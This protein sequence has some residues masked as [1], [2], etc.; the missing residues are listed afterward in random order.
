MIFTNGQRSVH[1]SAD[2]FTRVR[3]CI[4]KRAGLTVP[5]YSDLTEVATSTINILIAADS[6]LWRMACQGLIAISP[7]GTKPDW[8]FEVTHPKL[9][10]VRCSL[11]T[12]QPKLAHGV[13][14]PYVAREIDELVQ[15]TKFIGRPLSPR[16]RTRVKQDVIRRV[17]DL[18][19]QAEEA[20]VAFDRLASKFGR[21][22]KR[23]GTST[24]QARVTV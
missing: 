13:K 21:E 4:I 20:M 16:R 8:F 10:P 2:S 7:R 9:V 12:R 17:I 14:H 6:L 11:R 23:T 15:I 3:D 18:G 5:E 19:L 1:V 24:P 22:G